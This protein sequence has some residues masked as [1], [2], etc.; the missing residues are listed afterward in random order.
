M[1]FQLKAM[2]RCDCLSPNS[3]GLVAVMSD[4]PTKKNSRD[5]RFGWRSSKI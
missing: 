2:F 1:V 3:A 5:D 4:G